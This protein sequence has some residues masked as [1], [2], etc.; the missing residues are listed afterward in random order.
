MN[1]LAISD[2]HLNPATRQRSDLFIR[3]LTRAL[4]SRDE[5][6]IVGDLFD[7]WFGKHPFEY[8]KSVL[9]RMREL[10][11]QGLVL[12][13]VE[14]NRDFGICH[15]A[16]SPFRDVW[17]EAFELKWSG[18]SLYLVHGDLINTKDIPY[19][20]L[21]ALTKNPL[22]LRLIE[23]LPASF[24]LRRSSNLE[25]QMK[26]TNL[27]HKSRYPDEECSRFCRKHFQQG[28]DLVIAGH[29]HA[30]IEKSVQVD[31]RNVLFYNLPGWEQGFRYLVIPPGKDKPYFQG[32]EN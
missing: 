25:Q 20:F 10:S 18:R 22:S 12:H 23:S 21:R 4:D 17:P 13:Y 7:L 14:G 29:F 9:S 26:A 15:L 32:L 19:R 2:L 1:L 5:V 28:T 27:K 16:G 24:L 6:V 30:E 3:F 11:D 31:G 8:Q